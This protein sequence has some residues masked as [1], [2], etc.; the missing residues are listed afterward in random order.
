M[1][2]DKPAREKKKKTVP[3]RISKSN[4]KAILFAKEYLNNGCNASKAYATITNEPNT[5]HT[6]EELGSRMLRKVEVRNAISKEVAKIGVDVSKEF[7]QTEILNVLFDPKCKH[8]D[9]IKALDLLSRTES[10]TR[11]ES[12]TN[13]GVFNDV[14]DRLKEIIANRLGK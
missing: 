5:N 3:D 12:V 1:A 2:K 7:V 10:Y 13:I 4:I 8:S 6:T 14:E 11:P 9:K